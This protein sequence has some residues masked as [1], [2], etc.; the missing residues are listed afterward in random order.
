MTRLLLVLCLTVFISCSTNN[1]LEKDS[2][3]YK[4][5]SKLAEKVPAFDPDENRVIIK[6]ES[7]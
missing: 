6:M 7:R 5:A 2:E 1:K 4:L 3:D